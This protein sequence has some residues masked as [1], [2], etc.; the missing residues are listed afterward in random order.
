MINAVGCHPPKKEKK[1][2]SSPHLAY[3]VINTEDIEYP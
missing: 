1:N 2:I 3:A